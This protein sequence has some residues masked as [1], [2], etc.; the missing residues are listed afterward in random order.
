MNRFLRNYGMRL[1]GVI[2][3]IYLLDYLHVNTSV[4]VTIASLIRHGTAKCL[5]ISYER[6]L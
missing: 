3:Y 4:L 1:I 5:S 6:I 2:I